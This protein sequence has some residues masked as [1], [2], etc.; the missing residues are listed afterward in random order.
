LTLEDRIIALEQE[1]RVLKGEI[2]TTLTALQ[3]DLEA[4]PP[5]GLGERWSRRAWFLALLNLTLAIVLFVNVNYFTLEGLPPGLDP[6]TVMWLHGLWMALSFI[7]L[8]L[9][10]YPL[11][12]IYETQERALRRATWRNAARLLVSNPALL[13]TLTCA[14]LVVAL[15]SAFAPTVWLWLVVVMAVMVTGLG[16]R[17]VLICIDAKR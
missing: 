9:Q 4:T 8:M 17:R 15:V 6:E 10:L 16:L 1:N 5:R 7:W 11:T 14:V 13:V 12:L 3:A 2:Q